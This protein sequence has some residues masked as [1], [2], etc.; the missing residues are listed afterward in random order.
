MDLHDEILQTTVV[1][2]SSRVV[3]SETHGGEV[4]RQRLRR[5][6]KSVLERPSLAAGFWHGSYFKHRM[7]QRTENDAWPDNCTESFDDD[8]LEAPFE[9]K[10]TEVSKLSEI[11]LV[12]PPGQSVYAA[13]ASV[14]HADDRVGVRQ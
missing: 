9:V 7:S 11:W 14:H 13:R 2:I 1:A 8:V 3:R 12:L 4:P 10:L 5:C 6:P